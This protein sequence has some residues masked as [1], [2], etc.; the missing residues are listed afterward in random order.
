MGGTLAYRAETPPPPRP[1]AILVDLDHDDFWVC[2]NCHG[3]WVATDLE[4]TRTVLKET[5][6]IDPDWV[7]ERCKTCGGC[8]FRDPQSC[9][10]QWTGRG[11]WY[12]TLSTI[13]FAFVGVNRIWRENAQKW[14]VRLPTPQITPILSWWW[15]LLPP[16]LPK[17]C[18]ERG[19]YLLWE[20]DETFTEWIHQPE[21]TRWIECRRPTDR[22]RT[23]IPVTEIQDSLGGSLGSLSQ[24]VLSFP[25]PVNHASPNASDD[26]SETEGEARVGM[27]FADPDD[28]GDSQM[29]EASPLRLT[30]GQ[31]ATP[32]GRT[33]TEAAQWVFDFGV[34]LPLG[35][36]QPE[37]PQMGEETPLRLE[38]PPPPYS[39]G[40]QG[41]WEEFGGLEQG[42]EWE[43]ESASENIHP[44]PPPDMMSPPRDMMVYESFGPAGPQLEDQPPS[45]QQQGGGI[46]C[47]I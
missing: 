6:R 4:Y 36:G 44:L 8:R 13:P 42:V 11:W 3:F 27:I 1:V 5:P 33:P 25:N 43:G 15:T 30:Q 29:G 45:L 16:H 7:G 32:T 17:S 47:P 39:P 14:E 12:P 46:P 40:S 24:Y 26:E 18:R 28:D 41:P 19:G 23:R 9:P 38:G 35:E 21:I 2:P 37:S 10:D 22:A 31:E 20:T 34:R